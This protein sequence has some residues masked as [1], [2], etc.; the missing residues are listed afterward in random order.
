MTPLIS[1]ANHSIFAA[2]VAALADIRKLEAKDRLPRWLSPGKNRKLHHYRS[3]TQRDWLSPQVE[4]I[5]IV[6][7]KSYGTI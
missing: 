2:V 3:I 4:M 6:G 7:S 1:V 5:E